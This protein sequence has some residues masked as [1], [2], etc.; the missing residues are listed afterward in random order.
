MIFRDMLC[1]SSAVSFSFFV[2]LC[3]YCRFPL[4]LILSIR[5]TLEQLPGLENVPKLGGIPLWTTCTNET[6]KVFSLMKE[7]D[8]CI[9]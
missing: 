5:E 8:L 1:F 4:G 9:E 7:L 6:N 2:G 3:G